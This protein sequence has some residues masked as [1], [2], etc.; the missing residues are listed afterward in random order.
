MVNGAFP[1]ETEKK[2]AAFGRRNSPAGFRVTKKNPSGLSTGTMRSRCPGSRC[3]RPAYNRPG[4][5]IRNIRDRSCPCSLNMRR[6]LRSCSCSLREC[7]RRDCFPYA[8]SGIAC[9]RHTWPGMVP[10]SQKGRNL[11]R[12]RRSMVPAGSPPAPADRWRYNAARQRY[13]RQPTGRP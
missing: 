4:E 13:L 6:W 9:T 8:L 10:R 2:A 5:G 3:S 11:R 7:S 12:D 1:D